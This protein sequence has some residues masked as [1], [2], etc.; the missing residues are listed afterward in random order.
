MQWTAYDALIDAALAEDD[1][2]SDV[3]TLALVAPECRL[4]G[5][6]RARQ[7]LV[8]CGL[9]LAGRTVERFDACMV[10]EHRAEDGA[11]LAPGGVAAEIEGPAASVLAVERT[12][13]NFLQRLSG[14]ATLTARFVREVEGTGACICDTRK[15]TPGWRVL[16]K[17][18]V[19]C[20]GGRNHRM[21]LADQALIKDNH[22]ALLG[23]QGGAAAA[24]RA[25]RERF[26][27]RVVMVEVDDLEQLAA[28]LPVR[29][30]VVLLDNMSPD[31]VREAAGLARARG[32]DGRPLL[33]ASGGITLENVRRYAEAGAD[34][35][36]VG[37]LTHS[38]PAADLALDALG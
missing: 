31:Q 35:I 34:R 38:A 4:R 6:V 25:V 20:G 17:Y 27:D 10:L 24:V 22:L 26:P 1:A 13:L 11:R 36:S 14:V 16:E 5:Q 21:S 18:A 3:T 30:D 23:R 29:P 9:P 8:L 19:R 15:T 12:M 7:D 32:G 2:R 33:E 37:A 28:V